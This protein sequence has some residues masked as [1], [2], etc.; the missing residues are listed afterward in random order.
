MGR[1]LIALSGA[2]PEILSRCPSERRKFQVLGWSILFEGVVAVGS[3]WVALDVIQRANVALAIAASLLCGLAV[4]AANRWAVNSLTPDRMRRWTTVVPELALVIL[5]GVLMSAPFVLQVFQHDISRP[6]AAIRQQRLTAFLTAQSDGPTGQ[7]VKAWGND[8]NNLQIIQNLGG[9]PHSD[10]QLQTLINQR[11]IAVTQEQRW[12]DQWRCQLYGSASGLSCFP[13][14]DSALAMADEAEFFKY[15][16]EVA[17][18]DSSI[19]ER[20]SQLTGTHSGSKPADKKLANQI[21]DAK[22]KLNS[23]LNEEGT[24]KVTFTARNSADN[25]LL[26]R[27]AALLRL[28]ASELTLSLVVL[29]LFVIVSCLPALIRLRLPEGEY[30]MLLS[31]AGAELSGVQGHAFISYVHEDSSQVNWLEGKLKAAGIPVWRDKTAL[32]PGE[33]WKA[34]IRLAITQD[35]LAFIACFSE[36]SVARARSFQNEELVLAIEELRRRRPGDS[37]LI[38]VRLGDVDIPDIDIGAG[39]TLGSFHRADLFGKQADEGADR[40]IAAVLRILRPGEGQ[41]VPGGLLAAD[42]RPREA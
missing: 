17:Q 25:G 27:L 24:Q 14:G 5:L 19:K 8:L 10:P 32:W 15:R 20:Q 23:A 38:P 3:A 41:E 40:L 11:A 42:E 30:E 7:L 39:R 29:V 4:V 22:Q 16:N 28:T 13:P 36:H 12:Y 18:L 33:D 35:A 6:V 21:N 2:R 37:W 1:L 34:K 31:M 9:S 26:I